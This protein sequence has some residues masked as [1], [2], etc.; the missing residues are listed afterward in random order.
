MKVLSVISLNLGT[1]VTIVGILPFILHY[2]YSDSP[3]SDPSNY[4]ELILMI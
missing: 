1:I 2:P 3:Y 4:W